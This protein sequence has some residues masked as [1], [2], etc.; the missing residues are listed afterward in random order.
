MESQSQ[1]P[2]FRNNAENCHPCKPSGKNVDPSH[3]F[4]QKPVDLNLEC[5]P[6]I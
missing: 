6:K 5:I 3:W 1:N 2:E 4:H